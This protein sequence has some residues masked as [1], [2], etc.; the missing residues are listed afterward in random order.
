MA[1]R[2]SREP[3]PTETHEASVCRRAWRH[4]RRGDER[5]A[6]FLLRDAAHANES[7]AR[8]WTLYGVQCVRAGQLDVA[9]TALG[10]AAW[11]RARSGE[12]CKARVTRDFIARL[13]ARAA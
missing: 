10:H 3:E 13:R 11:L 2:R 6:M 8:L 5:R 7:D 1:R 9:L 4:R 12:Q